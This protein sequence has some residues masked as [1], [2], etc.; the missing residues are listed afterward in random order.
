MKCAKSYAYHYAEKDRNF[1]FV[2]VNNIVRQVAGNGKISELNTYTTGNYCLD[3]IGQLIE[4]V[5]I[6]GSKYHILKTLIC[7]RVGKNITTH[8]TT[9]VK[10]SFFENQ[11][12][13]MVA[14]RMHEMFN[15]VE[16]E[17]TED[18]RKE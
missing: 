18:H 13:R 17:S 12:D 5:T 11:Y 15:I 4:E 1:G 10:P 14:S 9:N 6:Y 7:E 16:M 3:D 2:R 8:G